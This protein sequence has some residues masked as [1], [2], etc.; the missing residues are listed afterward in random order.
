M[1][2]A[3]SNISDLFADPS[4]WPQ[5]NPDYAVLM[6]TYGHVANT[7]APDAGMALHNTA[8]HTPTVLSFVLSG[9]EDHVH[10][11]HSPQYFPGDLSNATAVDGCLI[12]LLG[13]DPNGL[14]PLAL[15]GTAFARCANTSALDV[16]TIVGP[17]G[18]AAAPPVLRQGPHAA[19]AAN[20]QAIRACPVL[21]LPPTVASQAVSFMPE[22]RYT[23]AAF[24]DQFV[25]GKHDSADP[26]EAALW[27]ETANW[28]R[29]A[30]TN[31][32]AGASVL[33]VAL[34]PAVL[35]HHARRLQS[36]TGRRVKDMMALIGVGGP[37]LSNNTFHT[38]EI[39]V[40]SLPN[41]NWRRVNKK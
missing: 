3:T 5:H 21:M 15:P 13:N 18:H 22:G 17:T 23:L 31:G 28:F 38:D 16:P 29:L 2:A 24:Y 11:V 7:T 12:V 33:R 36:H 34:V 40:Q 8:V 26:A 14:V 41:I 27:A 1:A 32:A 37:A 19:G 9:D 39:L 20:T 30:S 4:V 35:P 10:V 25:R 6:N